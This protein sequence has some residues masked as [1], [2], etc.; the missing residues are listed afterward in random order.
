MAH[1]SK[2]D[3]SITTTA[4]TI[5]TPVAAEV[6]ATVVDNVDAGAALL[7]VG[8]AGFAGSN[9]TAVAP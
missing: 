4:S 2:Q 3:Q 1:A 7:P 6:R 8:V 9:P 5:H